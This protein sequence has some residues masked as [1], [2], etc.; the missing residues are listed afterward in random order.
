MELTPTL[1]LTCIL[2]GIV[3]IIFD[4]VIKSNPSYKFNK[5][6]NRTSTQTC[7]PCKT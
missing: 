6:S 4:A 7:C 1:V 2:L 5:G 3:V